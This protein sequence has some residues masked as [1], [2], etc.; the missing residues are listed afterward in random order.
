MA[1]KNDPFA[2]VITIAQNRPSLYIFNW[3]HSY[4][5]SRPPISPLVKYPEPG[6]PL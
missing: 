6:A 3:T 5:H 4:G 2:A 1:K